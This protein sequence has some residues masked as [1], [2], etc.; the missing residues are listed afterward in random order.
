LALTFMGTP[1]FA[2][3]TLAKLLAAGHRIL[4]VY[5]RPPAQAG[6][7][8]GERLSPVHRFALDRGLQIETPASFKTDEAQRAFL[9]RRPDA[10]IVVAYGLILPG[11]VLAGSR[12]GSYNLH[13]S[14]LPR[15]RGAAPI[16][17]AIMAGDERTGVTIMRMTQGLDEGPICL[18]EAV[19][20][21]SGETAGELHDRLAQRGAALMIAALDRLERGALIETPQPEKGITYAAKIDKSETRLDFADPAAQVLSRIHGLSPQPGAWCGLSRDGRHHRLKILKAELASGGGRPGQIIDAD[22][23]IACG[24][25]ALR[26]LLVQR[27]GKSPLPRAEFLRG[28][29]LLPGDRLE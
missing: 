8:L 7:G 1:D 3:P 2:L 12:F 19:P 13:A 11:P 25:G 16:S 29:A 14:L 6:R 18:S 5:T 23:A 9:E 27:Q 24:Q 4:S 22:F 20:I 10:A 21:G 17:R 26:P 28:M 15:W